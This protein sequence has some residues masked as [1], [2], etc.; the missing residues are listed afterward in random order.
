MRENVLFKMGH[1]LA[2]NAA[3]KLNNGTCDDVYPAVKHRVYPVYVTF[4][5]SQ[6]HVKK[7]Q[8]LISGNPAHKRDETA[9]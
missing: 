4:A 5:N 1:I 6:S 9:R 7:L 8:R 2:Y 3:F